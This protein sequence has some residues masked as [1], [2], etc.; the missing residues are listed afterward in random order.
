MNL[1][2]KKTWDKVIYG[3]IYPGFLGSMLYE[4]VPPNPWDFTRQYFW[5]AD[6]RIRYLIIIFYFLDYMHL[7][8]DLEQAMENDPEV[9]D[10]SYFVCDIATSLLY[11]AAFLTVKAH[12]YDWITYLF[13]LVPSA[14][15]VY[16][17]VIYKLNNKIDS[18]YHIIWLIISCLIARALCLKSTWLEAYSSWGIAQAVMILNVVIYAFYVFCYF[19]RWSKFKTIEILRGKLK[20]LE[21][22]R[23]ANTGD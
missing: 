9:K 8:G 13:I 19:E 23:Q 21:E 10:F 11:L 15:L 2:N 14:F 1:G 6:H 22:I 7:Y 16:K 12:Q 5:S 3:L 4:L 17:G 20:R 18:I